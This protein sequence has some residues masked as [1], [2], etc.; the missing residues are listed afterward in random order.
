MAC[1]R[2]KMLPWSGMDRI[3]LRAM[4]EMA[5][6]SQVGL[7]ELAGYDGSMITRLENGSRALKP[8]HVELLRRILAER[9]VTEA[10]LAGEDAA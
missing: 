7:G 3:T 10:T 9:G 2:D 8:R 6:L 5:G 1:A 4:R